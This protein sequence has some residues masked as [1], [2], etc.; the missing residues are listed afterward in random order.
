VSSIIWLVASSDW[1]YVA[2]LLAGVLLFIFS[3][4]WRMDPAEGMENP[5]HPSHR[6]YLDHQKAVAKAGGRDRYRAQERNRAIFAVVIVLVCLAIL[7]YKSSTYYHYKP[8]FFMP[9]FVRSGQF[10]VLF[11]FS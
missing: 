1:I 9:D 5:E 6:I 4:V 10:F 7:Y 3:L 8:G 11:L 2:G